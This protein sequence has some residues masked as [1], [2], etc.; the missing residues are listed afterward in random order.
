MDTLP[1]VL[2]L[3]VDGVLL[4]D[5]PPW[6]DKDQVAVIAVGDER[7]QVRWSPQCVDA[8]FTLAQEGRVEIRWCTTW[9]PHA[10]LLEQLWKLPEFPRCWTEPIDSVPQVK[11]AKLAAAR[12]VLAAGRRLIWCD[13]DAIPLARKRREIGMIG[14]ALYIVP[15]GPRGL[16]PGQMRQIID[17]AGE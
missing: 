8:L 9:C 4:A 5:R 6:N 2:L 1:P 10:H 7:Y 3:D 16:S 13:D 17:F 14:D 15:Y 11:A 12:E